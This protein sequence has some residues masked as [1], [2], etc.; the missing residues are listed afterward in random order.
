MPDLPGKR[1][2]LSP[3][4]ENTKGEFELKKKSKAIVEVILVTLVVIA[5]AFAISKPVHERVR[6]NQTAAMMRSLARKSSVKLDSIEEAQKESNRQL[7]ATI[8]MKAN[9][10]HCHETLTKMKGQINK[11]RIPFAVID[12]NSRIAKDLQAQL[13][14]KQTPCVIVW[15]KE[16]PVLVYVGD[17]SKQSVNNILQILNNQNIDNHDQ[18]IKALDGNVLWYHNDDAHVVSQ[19]EIPHLKGFLNG[20]AQ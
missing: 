7:T 1:S 15:D 2:A 17:G 6:V 14:A 16:R 19:N 8:I 11:S 13:S 18:P 12:G 5:A 20:E 3:S 10:E 9:C 4:V